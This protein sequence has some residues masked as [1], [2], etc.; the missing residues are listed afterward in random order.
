MMNRQDAQTETMY[1]IYWRSEQSDGE[2]HSSSTF[3]LEIAELWVNSLNTDEDNR[4]VGL[5]HW[6]EV[7][8][9]REGEGG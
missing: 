4:R 3:S 2:R 7:E 5:Y 6:M 1:R 8:P 9:D